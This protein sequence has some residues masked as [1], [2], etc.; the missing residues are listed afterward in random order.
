MI[1]TRSFDDLVI[2]STHSPTGRLCPLP[3]GTSLRR[4]FARLLQES[5]D[6]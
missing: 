3:R 1:R 4:V 2:G 6:A 5:A